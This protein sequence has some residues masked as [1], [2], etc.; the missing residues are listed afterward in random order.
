MPP[1]RLV[2][3]DTT[4]ESESSFWLR[5]LKDVVLE[6]KKK[7]D[8][9]GGGGG[10]GGGGRG[11]DDEGEEGEEGDD[12]GGVGASGL[13][14]GDSTEDS[15]A[16]RRAQKE[17]EMEAE[18][19]QKWAHISPRWQTRLLAV[20]CVRRLL[21]VL[22]HPAH[23]DL[24]LAR[25]AGAKPESY[26]SEN[27]QE[28][29][30]VAFTASTSPLESVRPAGIATLFEIADRFGETDDP[31]Y[32]GKRLLELYAA[33][34]AHLLTSSI[35]PHISP[36]HPSPHT[37]PHDHQIPWPSL[38]L[39]HLSA[40]QISAA[41]RPCLSSEAEPALAAAGCA[42]TSRYLLA[43]AS[44]SRGHVVDPVAVRKLLALLV[45]LASPAEL[46]AISFPAYSESSATMVR[47]AALQATAQLLQAASAPQAPYVEL[48]KQLAPS[49]SGLRDAWLALLRD[50]ALLDTQPKTER[51]S[52]RPYLYAPATARAAHQ[53][54]LGAWSPCLAALVAIVPTGAWHAG[55]DGATSSLDEVASLPSPSAGGDVG[56]DLRKLTPRPA[57]ED[58]ALLVGLCTHRIGA[59]AEAGGQVGVEERDETLQCASA[60]QRLLPHVSLEPSA[61]VRLVEMLR[62]CN[63]CIPPEGADEMAAALAALVESLCTSAASLN[64]PGAASVVPPL[65]ALAAAPLLRTLPHLHDL[66]ARPGATPPPAL[67]PCPPSEALPLTIASLKATAALPAALSPPSA[68]IAHMPAA[69]LIVLHVCH[70]AAVHSLDALA[71]ASLASLKNLLA[72]LP[73]ADTNCALV[74][75]AAVATALGLLQTTPPTSQAKMLA[76]TIATVAALPPADAG[77]DA[78]VGGLHASI[79]RLLAGGVGEQKMAIDAISAE[80][81][82]CAAQPPLPPHALGLLRSVLPEVA[83]LLL[84]ETPSSAADKPAAFKLMV[85]ACA[86]APAD[87]SGAVGVVLSLALPLIINCMHLQAD[88]TPSAE[89]KELSTM[90]SNSLTALAKRSVNEFKAAAATFAPETRTRMETALREQAAAAAAPPTTKAGLGAPGTP[91]AGPPKI[92]LKMDF[93]GFGKK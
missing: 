24:K 50:L 69:L 16:A 71:D 59:Y 64:G 72:A 27:L 7:K 54:L 33:Q 85:L 15:E 22:Q 10:G 74:A 76:A 21:A 18:E 92:A 11:G 57:A 81:T 40:S 4:A 23:F 52:Y 61:I 78:I 83:P 66:I 39:S 77:D 30:S 68:R 37:S 31:D 65:A 62:A 56:H 41:L 14:A 91:A 87:G 80:L 25:D 63:D 44:S 51:R 29:I 20:E 13:P 70:A 28:L 49:L 6:T 89:A 35:S 86:L 43:I 93:G 75:R 82:R 47:A 19:A 42:A 73:S 55:R 79:A 88:G 8:S 90:A 67:P 84:R 2:Q 60:L 5:T 12:G 48:L 9:G 34:V 26:L 3:L 46:A 58:V 17:A 45:K 53:Q 38:T 32:D 36:Q 1:A